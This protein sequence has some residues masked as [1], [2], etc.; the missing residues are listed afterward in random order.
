[1][2]SSTR[3]D[4][5]TTGSDG[6]RSF[7]SNHQQYMDIATHPSHL[8][9]HGAIARQIPATSN[10]LPL[11]SFART[12]LHSDILGIPY[13]HLIETPPL[14][15]DDKT[16]EKLLW[17]GGTTG[18]HHDEHFDWKTTQRFRLIDTARST[19][20]TTVLIPSS[21]PSSSSSSSSP[22]HLTQTTFQKASSRYLDVGFTGAPIQCSE[23]DGTCAQIAKEYVFLPRMSHKQAAPYKYMLDVD[24]NAWS[25][26]FKGL[27]STG[28]VVLKSTIMPEWYHDRIQPWVHYVPVKMDYSD[29]F[30]VMAYVSGSCPCVPFLS[31]DQQIRYSSN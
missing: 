10:H 13:S 29:V 7:I 6:E 9:L 3:L 8:R 31:G 22:Y 17:R 15:W 4:R 5:L 25:A 11:F 14:D 19:N 16:N 26:R 30:D 28:S 23:S 18:G 27:L 12:S 20:Q 2:P 21:P 24:G 1:M